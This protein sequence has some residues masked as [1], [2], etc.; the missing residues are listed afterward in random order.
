MDHEVLDSIPRTV[1]KE[2]KNVK[3]SAV[4][5]QTY[6]S[7]FWLPWSITFCIVWAPWRGGID[8]CNSLE[9]QVSLWL[10]K[11]VTIQTLIATVALATG[12]SEACW[13]LPAKP[14]RTAT[15]KNWPVPQDKV[16]IP[17]AAWPFPDYSFRALKAKPFSHCMCMCMYACVY[18][19]DKGQPQ[20]SILRY[21]LSFLFLVLSLALTK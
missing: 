14:D 20:L 16:D 17:A 1:K 7:E 9:R 2:K 12:S 3:T 4:G 5:I 6:R 15:P 8:K 13:L 18:A 21:Q 19:Q 11:P 10:R